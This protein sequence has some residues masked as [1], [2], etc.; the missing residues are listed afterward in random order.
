MTKKIELT[1][2]LW[3]LVDASDYEYLN[4]YSWHSHQGQRTGFYARARIN[5]KLVYMHRLLL[6]PRRYQLV[7]HANHNGLDNRRDNIRLCSD[8]Q[9]IANTRGRAKSGYKGVICRSGTLRRPYRAYCGKKTIGW[10]E[11]AE[12]A[13]RAYNSKALEIYGPFAFLNSINER[14]AA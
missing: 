4:Q 9:N 11:T 5:G 1:K 13:A 7:D 10:F 12:Q 14:V 3:A 6:K 8:A 2:G